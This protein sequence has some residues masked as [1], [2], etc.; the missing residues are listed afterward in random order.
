MT[1]G[2]FAPKRLADAPAWFSPLDVDPKRLDA[3]YYDPVL[4]IA[5]RLLRQGG[6]FNWK[7]LRQVAKVYNFGAYEL[8]NHIKFVD[9]S[10]PGAIPYVTV[11]NIA[12]LTIEMETVPWIDG[13][14]HRLLSASQCSAGTVLVSIAGTIGR[15]GVVPW[16]LNECNGNQAI[17]KITVIQDEMDPHYLAAYLN[18][19]IGLAASAREAAGAVQKNLY[20]YNVEELPIP[21]TTREIRR[22]IGDR[23][24]AAERMRFRA[25]ALTNKS[26]Q[27][28]EKI[29]DGKL[30]ESACLAEGRKMAKE[31]GLEV[32]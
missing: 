9:Q 25:K 15:A 27:F 28:F 23:L 20:I 12:D 11:T 17:A 2:L 1:K 3:D 26:V 32:P 6:E 22:S 7:R 18:S 31:F 16:F 10:E 19:S 29:A 24:R 13:E 21:C 30:D 5:D 4:T 8:T 14:T